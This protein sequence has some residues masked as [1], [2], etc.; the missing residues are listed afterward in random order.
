MACT[1]YCPKCKETLRVRVVVDD[2]DAHRTPSLPTKSLPLT[3]TEFDHQY[4]LP[5]DTNRYP[6]IR[7]FR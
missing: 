2:K 5:F 1:I 3:R 4:N 7:T 6:D